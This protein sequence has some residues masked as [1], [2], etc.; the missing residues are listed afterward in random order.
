MPNRTYYVTT[1]IYYVNDLPHIGHMFTTTV[2]DALARYHRL[3]G[4]DVRFL[5]GTDEHG[6]NIERAAKREGI[7]PIELA[8]RVVG[9]YRELREK[10]DFSYDDFVRTT[11]ERHARGVREI[12]RRL[13]AAGDLY[14]AVHE[15]WYCSPCETFYTEKELASAPASP[16]GPPPA[17][18]AA[19][20]AGAASAPGG[21]DRRC[22][23][24][25]TAVEWKSE[26]NVFFR[27][28]R[29]QQ[30]L[31]DWYDSQ[32]RPVH[33]ASR[34]NEVRSF[35]A[36]GLR[37]LSVSR[38][39]LEWG[40]PFPGRPGQTVY[41][42]LDALTNYVSALG[43]GSERPEDV[44]LYRRFWEDGDVRL[45]MMG[46]D[47]V[48]FHAVYWPAFL[49]S[50]RLPLPTA[51]WAHGWW[52]RDGR[53]VSKSAGNV[54][55]PDELVERFGGDTLRYFLLREMAFGQDA[56]FSD[57]AVIDRYNNDLANDLGN[58]VSRVVTLSRS[59]FGGRTPY[60]SCGD[61]PLIEV[62]A[63]AAS[64]YRAAMDDLAFQRALES[65][66]RL[67][68]E[69][70]QY[71]VAHA[72]WKLIKTEGPSPKLARVLWNG[73]EATRIVAIGLLP[74][75]PRAAVKVL[76][77]IGAPVPQRL[78]AMTWGGTPVGTE[79]PPPA[80][81][82]PRIDKEAYVAEAKQSAPP[83]APAAPAAPK[84]EP[85]LSP[86]ALARFRTLEYQDDAAAPAALK[87]EP[88]LSPVALARF[89]TLQYQDDPAT[90][91]PAGAATPAPSSSSAAPSQVG[92]GLHPSSSP[93]DSDRISIDR[94]KQVRLRIGTVRAAELVPKS[95]KLLKLTVDLGDETQTVV[96]GIAH[97]YRPEDLV[98]KQVVVVA[99]LEPATLM[100]V[101]S[102]GMVLAA[103]V[104]GAP[105]LLHPGEA[106]PAGTAVR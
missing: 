47:I 50:A 15:G 73:L 13:D 46:K 83:P 66:W 28:S 21:P 35:V 85:E 57:E 36:G 58:T 65:L 88:E 98:G 34:L 92:G 103:S 68:A 41:V 42:W 75:M 3:L 17:T 86:V 52:Q 55:R 6:Q 101:E 74:I 105:V 18:V 91:A 81:I 44:A 94:F 27:L 19:G 37:D 56:S 20:A 96:A 24:H 64:D 80:P 9:R 78:D 33:P 8:D 71:L 63:R 7:T 84:P 97:A 5:T 79:L 90:P 43:L 87:P 61:N 59:A 77:A 40:I 22:P 51:V 30:P 70:N 31:L 93:G 53:K 48:R 11:E 45:H 10:L 99:N 69:T 49:M 72:P 32:P 67:L 82:F 100:G 39:N 23:V 89:R 95:K 62:A 26:E 106:V 104:D 4:E 1:P 2:C 54:V 38:A 16:P 25:G 14:A 60:Q 29:Y 76:R 102:Q 12:I